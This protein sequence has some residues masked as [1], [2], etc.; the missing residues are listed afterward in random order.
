MGIFTDVLLS[1]PEDIESNSKEGIEWFKNTLQKMS[2]SKLKNQELLRRETT[3]TNVRDDIIGHMFMFVYDALYKDVLPYYDR[4]PLVIPMDFTNNGFI[5]LNLHYIAPKYRAI[6]LEELYNL[7]SDDELD[8]Q[9]RF[10]LSYGLISKVSRFR[11]GK[12]CVKRYLTSHIDG[13]LERVEPIHW[14]LV[15]QLP[16]ARFGKGTNTLTVYKESRKQF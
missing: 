1:K 12:P 14:S 6:L 16:S 9:T 4:F 7:I 3:A 10:K 2:R 5:G 11:Y 8:G 15:S 13:Q